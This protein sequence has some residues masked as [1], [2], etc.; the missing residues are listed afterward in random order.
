MPTFFLS[1]NYGKDLSLI[2]TTAMV[3]SLTFKKDSMVYSMLEND[4]VSL[5][6][7]SLSDKQDTTLTAPSID[8]ENVPIYLEANPL[9]D[10]QMMMV[11]TKNDVYVSE[12]KETKWNKVLSNGETK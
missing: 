9:N 11:T 3:T 2:P 5:H 10:G 8:N 4:K 7:I 1:E 12:D 6:E